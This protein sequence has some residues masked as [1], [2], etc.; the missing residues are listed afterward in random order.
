MYVCTYVCVYTCENI[1]VLGTQ[2]WAHKTIKNL[3]S[4]CQNF[5]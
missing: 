1:Y 5:S 3:G 2:S 4:I